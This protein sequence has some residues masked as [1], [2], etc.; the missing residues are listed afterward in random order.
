M[1]NV[2]GIVAPRMSTSTTMAVVPVGPFLL[3]FVPADCVSHGEPGRG[4]P[5]T[6]SHHGVAWTI[7]PCRSVLMLVLVLFCILCWSLYFCKCTYVARARAF[8]ASAGYLYPGSPHASQRRRRTSPKPT[9]LGPYPVGPLEIFATPHT[10]SNPA[11]PTAWCLMVP[12]HLKRKAV[13]SW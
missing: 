6:T 8:N 13:A 3:A 7:D 9:A 2:N 5:R 4:A 1:I 10:D 12:T 11:E